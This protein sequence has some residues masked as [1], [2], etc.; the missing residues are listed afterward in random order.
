MGDWVVLTR[1]Q[2]HMM[3]VSDGY[4]GWISVTVDSPVDQSLAAIHGNYRNN[5][6]HLHR[7]SDPE[8][9]FRP[10]AQAVGG[11]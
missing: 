4:R 3:D 9:E 2:V 5:H 11:V 7:A 10:H 1:Q 6:E 8:N